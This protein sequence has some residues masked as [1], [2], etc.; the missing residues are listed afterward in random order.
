[1]PPDLWPL[2]KSVD[3]DTDDL[4]AAI[5][6]TFS[7]RDTIVPVACPIFAL[8]VDFTGNQAF[9]VVLAAMRHAVQ[10]LGIAAH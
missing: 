9:F 3:I 6:G 8:R 1:M 7:R 10:R 4:A 5:Q 2:P